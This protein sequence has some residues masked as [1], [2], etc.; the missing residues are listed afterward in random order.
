MQVS[1]NKKEPRALLLL[2]EILLCFHILHFVY[3]L[4]SVQ[5]IMLHFSLM[6]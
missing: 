4:Q 1:V 3:P 5:S 6:V 2:V